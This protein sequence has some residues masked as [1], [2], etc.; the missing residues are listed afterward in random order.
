MPENLNVHCKV[1]ADDTK[2]YE[3]AKKHSEIQEDLYQMQ[4]WTEKWN[5][6]FNVLKCKVM[7]IGKS[8][9][10][11]EYFM[12]IENDKQRLEKCEEE[13]DLGITFD[14]NLNFE[15]H[16]SNIT[17]KANQMLGIIRRTFNYMDKNIMLKLYKALVRSHL[18]YGNIVWSPYLKKQSVQIER[19]QRRATKLAPECKEM[20]YT[21]RLQYLKL[22]SLKGRRIRGDLIQ[23]YKIF[24]QIDDINIEKIL[25]LAT[26][27]R[28]RNQEYKL[29]HRYSNKD[30][31]KYTFTYR[32]VNLWNSLP[33]DIKNAPT[34]NTFKNRIDKHQK[35][36]EIFYE[37]DE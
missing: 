32:V 13:K 16:I 14:S 8:N 33:M 25:P 23:V 1:F 12:K 2:I 3:N 28:T 5:L 19:I 21:Q 24:Q 7:H 27:S 26:Y 30:I 18:E 10:R 6:Y 15:I 34:L 17:K 35:L 31:R 37:Y 36:L 22:F 29:R 4:R 11:H 9:P 20:N